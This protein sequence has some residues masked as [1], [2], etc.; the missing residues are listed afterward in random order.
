[1]DLRLL[2]LIVVVLIVFGGG[3]AYYAPSD[4]RSHYAG[5]GLAVGIVLVALLYLFGFLGRV[6]L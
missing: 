4:Y 3:P 1:M 2:L 6:R 5:G